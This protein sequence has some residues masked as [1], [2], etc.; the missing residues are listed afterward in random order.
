M[1]A[2]T[3]STLTE[4]SNQLADVIARASASVVQ[5]AGRRQPASGVVFDAGTIVTTAAAIGGE[6]AARVRTPDGRTLD[7]EIVG[8]DPASHLVALKASIDVPPAVLAREVPRVGHLAAAIGRSWSNALTASTGIVS[9]I[10]GPLA[11][12]RHHKIDEVIRTNARMHRG[13]AG[14]AFVNTS[15]E[16]VGI[17]TA[18]SIRGLGVVIPG[19]IAWTTIGNLVKHGRVRRG[20]LG[21]AGQ[22]VSLPAAQRPA[23]GSAAGVLVVQVLEGS[24]AEQ[25]GILVGDVLLSIDDH[26]LTTSEDLLEAL[27]GRG[28]ATASL[29][30]LRATNTSELRVA[31]GQK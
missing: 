11:T 8:W 23:D 17:L 29:R 20:Y 30:V 1:A 6:D 22:A 10:G 26:P 19:S 14:G 27:S 24:P 9:V 16:L 7:A 25:A 15:G 12:G 13:F 31:I 2:S 28:G 21:V 4:F 5:V 3:P 18:A